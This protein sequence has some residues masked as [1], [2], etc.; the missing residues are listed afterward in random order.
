M[1]DLFE[2]EP[3]PQDTGRLAE[4][5][6]QDGS[7]LQHVWL[8]HT[9]DGSLFTVSANKRAFYLVSMVVTQKGGSGACYI[10]VTDGVGGDD[11]IVYQQVA[12]GGTVS[13][14]FDP[15]AKFET[16]VYVTKQ[17]ATAID[18][19]NTFGT[20]VHLEGWEEG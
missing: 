1:T 13:L 7:E 5:W 19:R 14:T 8:D 11:V 16:S 2:K 18:F 6:Q 4:R 10:D 15:P 20:A 3:F 17:T 12:D 9:G